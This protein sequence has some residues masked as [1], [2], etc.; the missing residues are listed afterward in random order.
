MIRLFVSD[1]DGCLGEP[2]TP[3]DLEGLSRLR[4]YVRTAGELGAGDARPPLTLCSGRPY[5][6]VEA[7]TQALDV[8]VPVL[9]E[10]GGGRFD[11]VTA[12]TTWSPALSDETEANVHTVE[13][14]FK[15][16]C[17]PGTSLSLDYAKRTQAGVVSPDTEEIVAVRRQTE[18][19]VAEKGLDL[20]VFS[21]DISVDVI[22]P[23]ITKVHGLKWLS[24][25]LGVRLDEM[26]YIGDADGDLEALE[27]VGTSFAP[28]NA[29][30]EVR[31]AVDYV[32]DGR[33][34][35]GTLEAYRTCVQ[36]NNT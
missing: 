8:S 3:Y 35:D 18:S 15:T 13:E 19:F 14:W 23:G 17:I 9:F 26:A 7:I 1:I 10:A 4:E 2:Y 12:Q 30:A 20:H 33:V 6:Y 32:T 5:P 21:T 11:P 29:V 24:D 16:Q 31:D 34:L 36:Q 27:A 28:A 25:H 22:P